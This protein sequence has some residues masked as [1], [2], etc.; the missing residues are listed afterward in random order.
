MNDQSDTDGVVSN[1]RPLGEGKG[2]GNAL[3][4]RPASPRL[5]EFVYRSVVLFLERAIAV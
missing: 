5:G 2:E 4:S 3:A 1:P